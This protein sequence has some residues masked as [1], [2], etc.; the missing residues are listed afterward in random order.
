MSIDLPGQSSTLWS[1][2]MK[3]AESK[4]L[5]KKKLHLEGNSIHQTT[6]WDDLVDSISVHAYIARSLM[7]Q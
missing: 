3:L 7:K 5:T 2:A 1:S 4:E 6:G